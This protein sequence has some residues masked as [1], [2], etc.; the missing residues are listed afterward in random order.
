MLVFPSFSLP[1]ALSNM[2]DFVDAEPAKAV[3]TLSTRHCCIP[4][5]TSDP[6]AVYHMRHAGGL[7]CA[8]APKV[9]YCDWTSFRVTKKKK[10]E[11]PE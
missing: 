1:T 6:P 11:V 4:Y 7:E 2:L 10:T 3:S 8:A 5:H 9:V